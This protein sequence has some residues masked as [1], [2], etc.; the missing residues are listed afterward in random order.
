MEFKDYYK[1]LGVAEQADASAIKGEFIVTL[2]FEIS[3]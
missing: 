3:P 1:I 2:A